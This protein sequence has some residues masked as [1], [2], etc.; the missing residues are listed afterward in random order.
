MI[1]NDILKA[2]DDGRSPIL[3][4]NRISHVDYFEGRLKDFVRNIIVL[5]GGWVKDKENQFLRSWQLYQTQRNGF[6]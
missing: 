4:T 5:K 3:L 1:F 6:W 2:L